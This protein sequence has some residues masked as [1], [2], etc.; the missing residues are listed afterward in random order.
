MAVKNK[1]P[2]LPS[3]V[4][5]PAGR[6]ST[7]SIHPRS[8]LRGILGRWGDKQYLGFLR[9]AAASPPLRIGDVD[10]NVKK[11]LE[12][13]KRADKESVDI[14]V[15]PELSITA[16]TAS[17]LFFNR[18]LLAQALNGLA[19]IRLASRALGSVLVVGVPIA[20]EGKL[21]NTAA[22]VFK[23]KV[24]GLVPK[25]YVPGYKEFYEERWFASARDLVVKEIM[26]GGQMIPFGTDILFRMPKIS[27][28]VLGVEICE[29]LWMPMPPSSFQVL[30][31]ATIIA[32][33][34]ASND[35]VG[36][37]DYRRALVT[38]Q[39]ARG[40][41][42]YVYSSCGVHESTTDVVFG[43]HALIAENGA[44]L[45]ESKRFIREGEM[46][47]ADIDVEH[48]LVDRERMTSFG[49][50]IHESPQKEFRIIDIPLPIPFHPIP[51]RFIDPNPFVP[52]NPEERDLRAKEIFS[53]QVAGLA[54]RLEAAKI[55]KM[56]LGLSGGLDSTLALLVA[57]KTAETLN[58][59]HKN[60]FTYTMPGFG[61][62]HRTKN[63][64]VKL[65]RA[66]GVNI[67][68]IDIIK[69]VL[70]Q[71]KDIKHSPNEENTVFENA[72]ARYRTYTLMDKANQIHGLVIG[73]GDLSEIA[74]GW[75]TYTGDH[76][77]HYNVN[78]S[79]PKTLVR[80]LVQWAAETQV[81]KKTRRILEDILATPIS[82]ELRKNHKPGEISH[83]TEK[84]IG[85]YE[86][87]D[88]FLYHFIRWVSS[89]KKILFLA[90][91][92]WGKKYKTPELKK[93]LK[94]FLQ[95]FFG[96]QWKRSVATDGPKVGS[97][98]LSPRGDWRM[99]SDAE[100]KMW[101]EELK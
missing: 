63:N 29:D 88:F 94:V 96:S 97:V 32:N 76:I 41:C 34:S 75:N 2:H 48:M 89:P 80:Y 14:L 44:L 79:V 36:K 54:K 90:E 51:R 10:Y 15:F 85:P 93:W 43:G 65:A 86:L 59:P 5:D 13:A 1:S 66:L 61:T 58:L 52:S 33:L 74:L 8:K 84:L 73:T 17:D 60:I 87:H 77:A 100:V 27:G 81:D 67:E 56:I 25:T 53:I 78:C 6:I 11:I 70:Q 20:Q 47:L 69:G 101:S 12:F 72:Q 30:R 9:L 28:A 91:H 38:Q 62:S 26:L 55:N 82:P 64:A 22:V 50:S 71:F 40:V 46:T 92:S 31:G 24:Y 68:T 49:E 83:R 57:V 42:A 21:F 16:Y 19:R 35:L 23:G 39:S 3:G 18:T 37:A 98:S 45:A 4:V 95:R 7:A 99:P